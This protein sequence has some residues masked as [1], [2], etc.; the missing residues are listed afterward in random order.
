MHYRENWGAEICSKGW[1]KQFIGIDMENSQ[2]YNKSIDGI[3]GSTISVNSL[4]S[5]VFKISKELKIK[6]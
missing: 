3:S 5:D 1:L 4:K 6:L 2:I